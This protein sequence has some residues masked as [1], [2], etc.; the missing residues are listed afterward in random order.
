M[1]ALPLTAE[2]LAYLKLGAEQVNE[3]EEGVTFF[4]PDLDV[5]GFAVALAAAEEE[6][7]VD[8][9]NQLKAKI[10]SAAERERKRYITAGSG[11]AMTYAQKAEEARQCLSVEGPDAQNFPLLAAE[12]GITAETLIG[13]AQVVATANAQWLQIGAAIEAARLSTKKAISDAATPEAALAA[14][15]AVVWP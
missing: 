2:A 10:D 8:L 6:L 13:V 14:A 4:P 1:S 9:K 3:S 12:I 15:D 11:Q 7:F 5:S